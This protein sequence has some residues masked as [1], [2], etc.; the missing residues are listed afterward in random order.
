MICE[1]SFYQAWREIRPDTGGTADETVI[2]LRPAYSQHPYAGFLEMGQQES[3]KY[4]KG[5]LKFLHDAS[6]EAFEFTSWPLVRSMERESFNFQGNSF[7]ETI[8]RRMDDVARNLAWRVQNEP[9]ASSVERAQVLLNVSPF[10][11]IARTALIKFAWDKVRGQASDWER[12]SRSQPTVLLALSEQYAVHQDSTSAERLLQSISE[13]T[14]TAEFISALAEQYAHAGNYEAW[15]RTM[16]RL[17]D[18]PDVRDRGGTHAAIVEECMNRADWPKAHEHADAGIKAGSTAG[19]LGGARFYEAQELWDLAEACYRKASEGDPAA[20]FEWYF[21]CKR[22][23]QGDANR[24]AAIVAKYMGGRE[25]QKYS[26]PRAQLYM[27][28]L[29][30]TYFLLAKKPETAR[31]YFD[32]EFVRNGDPYCGLE[33]ALISDHLKDLKLRDQRLADI[34]ARHARWKQL[35]PRTPHDE[36]VAV[37]AMLAADLR[38]KGD[39]DF[40]LTSIDKLLSAANEIERINCN[41]FIGEYLQVH[42]KPE[43]AIHWWMKCMALLP[44]GAASRTLAGSELFDDRISPAEYEKSVKDRTAKP[45]VG[46]P[47]EK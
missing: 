5:H 10:H 20:A 25:A 4:R 24:A 26:D 8:E 45:V 3:I 34:S 30:G 36:L 9:N 37:A 42:G 14:P 40:D 38:K 47:S 21:F 17:A 27:Q 35:T 32:E 1:V 46:G 28:I 6:G 41:Y 7:F 2:K 23:G 19:L 29:P 11:P 15:L 12:T 16:E 39:G 18:L 22:T 33:V 43:K 31:Q 44:V 13:L